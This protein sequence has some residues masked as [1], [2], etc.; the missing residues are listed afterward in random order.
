MATTTNYSWATPD[1]TDLVKDGAAAIRTLGSSVDSTVYSLDQDNV[2]ITEFVAK[3]DLLGASAENTPARLGVGANDTVLTADSTTAT[4][5]KWAAPAGGGKSFALLNAGGT[6]LSGTTTTISSLS[7]YDQ[8]F[9]VVDQASAN[10]P[11]FSLTL[12]LSGDTGSNYSYYGARV[13]GPS[14]YSASTNGVAVNQTNGTSWFICKGS[15]NSNSVINTGILIS[16]A[17]STGVKVVQ[18]TAGS[19]ASGGNSQRLQIAS[20]IWNNSSVVSSISI[21]SDET[22]DSGTVYIYGAV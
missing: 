10:N 17:N 19:T 14:A 2:K 8:F 12:R 5:L 16:G 6:S 1:D 20:G 15:S 3:G 21:I 9:V 7:G 11:N 18:W 13:E 22:Y 4:G